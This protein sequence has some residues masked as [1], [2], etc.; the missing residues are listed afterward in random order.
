MSANDTELQHFE[1][2]ILESPRT[3]HSVQLK[4]Y[5]ILIPVLGTVIITTNFLVV[6]SSGLIL[7][8][9]RKDFNDFQV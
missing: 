7:R 9:S 4:L 5:D 6:I 8:K 1:R 2:E 3:A